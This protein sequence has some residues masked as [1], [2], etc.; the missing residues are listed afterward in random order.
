MIETCDKNIPKDYIIYNR[1]P[2]YSVTQDKNTILNINT[3]GS[4]A[5]K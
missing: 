4:L 2:T 5:D 1:S 3:N